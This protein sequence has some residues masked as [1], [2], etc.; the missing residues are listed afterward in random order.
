M[1]VFVCADKLQ[2]GQLADLRVVNARGAACPVRTECRANDVRLP[3]LV[4]T[5]RSRHGRQKRWLQQSTRYRSRRIVGKK[6]NHTEALFLMEASLYRAYVECPLMVYR[7]DES[8]KRVEYCDYID[9]DLSVFEDLDTSVHTKHTAP[10]LATINRI[11]EEQARRKSKRTHPLS[12]E[13]KPKL[14]KKGSSTCEA[15]LLCSYCA[16]LFTLLCQRAFL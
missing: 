14:A 12:P 11:N 9:M 5:W 13:R 1:C 8:C 2:S 6:G 10:L 4:R 7:R 16:M 15:V 3:A